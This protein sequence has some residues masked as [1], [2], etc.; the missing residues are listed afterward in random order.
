MHKW[1]YAVIA[2]LVLT[3]CVLTGII[4]FGPSKPELVQADPVPM[5][6]IP[7]ASPGRDA[8]Q[9]KIQ[10]LQAR[11][12]ELQDQKDADQQVIQELW[13]MLTD[14]ARAAVKPGSSVKEPYAPGRDTEDTETANP[15]DTP[16][17]TIES[18]REMLTSA[19]GDL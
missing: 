19:G 16:Q 1:S 17:Y 15:D 13:G 12:S 9:Q 4:V 18:V 14:S 6:Q 3:V 5:K 7:V 2:V 8:V 11:V 10:S